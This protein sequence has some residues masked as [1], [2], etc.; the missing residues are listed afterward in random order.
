M[1]IT[2][3]NP[4]LERLAES[5]PIGKPIFP[6]SVVKKFRQKI[7]VLAVT[8]SIRELSRIKGLNLEALKGSRAG[9]FSIRIDLKYRLIFRIEPNDV[10]IAEEIIVDELSNHYE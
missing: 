1:K 4:Y 2:F 7:S 5:D 8:E 9:S 10:L 3:N 6:Q